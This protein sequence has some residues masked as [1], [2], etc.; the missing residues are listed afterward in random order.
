VYSVGSIRQ[1]IL[2][3]KNELETK[4]W[5]GLENQ[6]GSNW[7][8]DKITKLFAHTHTLKTNNGVIIHTD[9]RQI[10]GTKVRLD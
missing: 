8:I 1:T 7:A 9:P 4:F 10:R 5:N 3:L 2:N 6:V